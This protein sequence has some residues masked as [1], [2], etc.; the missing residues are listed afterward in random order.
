M[1]D[2]GQSNENVEVPS[3]D[4]AKILLSAEHQ[5]ILLLLAASSI[6]HGLEFRTAKPVNSSEYPAELQI[7]RPV[8]VTLSADNELRGCV[9]T[10]DDLDSLVRNV[11]KYAFKSAFS[12]PRFP[13]VKHEEISR[14]RIQIS[15]LNRPEAL[16]FSSE[17]ELVDQLRPGV[18]GLILEESTLRSTLLP[19]AWEGVT[20]KALFLTQLKRKAGFPSN[21]WSDSL[22]IYRYTTSCISG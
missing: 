16:Q 5:E 18:D 11:A 17:D 9:G 19:S 6:E 21:Y 8:F 3:C 1:E 10:L 20:D 13:E 22:K 14:L 7:L 4:C 15:I 2:P 12:D